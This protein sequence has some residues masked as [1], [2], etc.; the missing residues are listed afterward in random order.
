MF[1]FGSG[2]IG[3]QDRLIA[4][5][6]KAVRRGRVMKLPTREVG[7]PPPAFFESLRAAPRGGVVEPWEITSIMRGPPPP[8]GLHVGTLSL[9][10]EVFSFEIAPRQGEEVIGRIVCVQRGGIGTDA[11]M[12]LSIFSALPRRMWMFTPPLGLTT[13]NGA[14]IPRKWLEDSRSVGMFDVLAT[15]LVLASI[16]LLVLSDRQRVM[17]AGTR[18]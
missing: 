12:T 4:D 10:A 16:G 13:L 14:D 9:P 15:E 7:G 8:L 11:R 17:N 18:H 2:R 3:P 6:E 5:L 1:G